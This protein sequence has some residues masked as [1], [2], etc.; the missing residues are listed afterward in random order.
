MIPRVIHYCWFGR[1][2]KN[3]LIDYCIGTWKKY[4]PNYKILEWNEDNYLSINKYFLQ[5]IKA[6]K[7]SF[8]SDY[9]RLDIIYKYG[10]IYLDT[11]VELIQSLDRLIELE[12][13][14]GTEEG[15]DGQLI[16]TGLGFGAEA[17]H[18]AV[19]MM[20]DEYNDIC[21]ESKKGILDLTPCPKR[22]TL[23]FVRFGYKSTERVQV[24][25]GATIYP[26]E[27]FSPKN[28]L[29]RELKITPNTI[30]IHH[31][32]GGWMPVMSKIRVR[33]KEAVGP[34]II[35]VMYKLRRI[36]IR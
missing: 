31:Y 28:Y 11:D 7:W 13:F 18:K 33:I 1:N 19:K 6:K 8:A 3:R 15:K 21:F 12:C 27:Y 25:V 14:L 36:N 26:A 4:C 16:A 24:I 29:T 2:K 10:G 5:A 34:H 17:K 20:L 35:K 23:P 22:N 32:D 9:A 30:S